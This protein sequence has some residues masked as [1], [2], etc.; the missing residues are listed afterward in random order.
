MIN[1]I[2]VTRE[3]NVRSISINPDDI[4]FIQ[5]N[6]VLTEEHH[7]EAIAGLNTEHRFSTVV[8][9]S[10][11]SFTVVGSQEYLQEKITKSKKSLLLG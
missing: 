3:R 5:E 6:S 4:S 8:M 1:L 9:R 7:K 10:G 11:H 2:E